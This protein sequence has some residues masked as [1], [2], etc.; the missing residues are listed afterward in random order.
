MRPYGILLGLN[1]EE[2]SPKRPT[3]RREKR[4]IAPVEPDYVSRKGS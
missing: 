2:R 1:P 3:G 4:I